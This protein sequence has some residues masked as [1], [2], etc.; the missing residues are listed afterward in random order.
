MITLETIQQSMSL[1]PLDPHLPGALPPKRRAAL[2][3]RRAPLR[4]APP[5]WGR[6]I[7][8]PNPIPLDRLLCS[9]STPTVTLNLVP[10]E[11]GKGH[12]V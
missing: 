1:L 11:M 9:R 7:P 6:V 4:T 5:N 3:L 12:M 10:T 8:S 2:E